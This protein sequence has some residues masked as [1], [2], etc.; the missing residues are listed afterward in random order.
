[1]RPIFR[2]Y[3][4]ALTV[5]CVHGTA[6]A[7]ATLT[8]VVTDASGAI[9]PGVTVET[10][11]P[12]LIERTRTTVTDGGGRYRIIDLP[13][14]VYE[15]TFTLPSFT[16]VKRGGVELEGTFI[17]T[18]NIQMTVGGITEV[19]TIE[20]TTPIVNISSAKQEDVVRKEDVSALPIARD[21]F[22]IA[23]L[24]PGMV[25]GTS[26][27]I[28][29]L[30]STKA[31]VTSFSDHGGV[32]AGRGTEGRLQ[33]DGLST[34]A[35]AL[36]GTGTGA[37]M[38]DISN[39]QEI[40]VVSSGGLGSSETGG[41]VINV[42]PRS[43]GNRWQGSYYFN[44]ANSDMQGNNITDELKAQNTALAAPVSVIKA[45]DMVL[46]GGGPIK[47]DHAWFWATARRN[48]LDQRNAI[49]Y[50][51]NAGDP[52]K[53]TYEQGDPSLD[54]TRFRQFTVRG[55]WQVSQKNKL[56]LAWDQSYKEVFYK[57]GGG[58]F[59]P[60]S[61]STYTSPEAGI[62]SDARPQIL[63]QFS[64]QRPHTNRLLFDAAV[65]FYAAHT[66]GQERPGN[67]TRDL[68]GVRDIAANVPG[69]GGQAVDLTYRSMTQIG[70]NEYFA[71]RWRA[72]AAY[73]RWSHNMRVGYDGVWF[74]ETFRNY[75]NNTSLNYQFQAG[76]PTM[77]SVR[78]VNGFT[79]NSPRQNTTQNTGVYFEDS[80]TRRRL[81]VQG[82]LRFDYA[83]SGND[84]IV[85]GPG[86]YFVLTPI[87]LPAATSVSGYKD[88]SPRVGLAYDV[89][90]NGRTA[91]KFNLGR[92][93]QEASN[94]GNYNLNN[95]A[96][97]LSNNAYAGTGFR[98]WT[99]VDKDFEI[100]CDITNPAAQGPTAAGALR[101]VDSCGQVTLAALGTP[102]ASTTTT[103]P[104]VLH[105]WGVRPN[106]WQYGIAVQQELLPRLSV[107]VGYRRRWFGNF[108]Y[109]NNFGTGAGCGIGI[110]DCVT[111]DQFDQYS[112]IAPVDSRLP[113][114][115]GYTIT[116]LYDPKASFGTANYITLEDEAHRRTVRWQ[117]VDIN[118]TARMHNGLIMRGGW[119]QAS[120]LTDICNT[121]VDN[122]EGLRT[123]RT[124]TPWAANA[125]F[126]AIY[127]TPKIFG[128]AALERISL[129]GVLNARPL[130]VKAANYNVPNSQ[131]QA[132][133]GR[134]PTGSTTT[135]GIA[136]GSTAKNILTD[137]LV[138]QTFVDTQWNADLRVSKIFK[139]GD[140]RLDAGVDVYNFL[141]FSSITS[142]DFAFTNTGT[143]APN[144]LRPLSIET[145]R[146]AKVYFQF[147]F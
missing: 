44:F 101:T 6:F 62:T 139:I 136:N 84:E 72:S 25:V 132:S 116:G 67:Q 23:S 33:V 110:K 88:L 45:Q 102:T 147:D 96:A 59:V 131:I 107:E 95:Q 56:T 86:K 120:T 40:S 36:F 2:A 50:N 64:W 68:I 114:G 91:L 21:W 60:T 47:R 103:D 81:T 48:M 106:D 30:T 69:L 41:P 43:G 57:G 144:Y 146:F 16:T 128:L 92:Y 32:S 4:V 113:D 112:I 134:P 7:Q 140:R 37:Y 78:A 13:A 29:G 61:L 10:A 133:L 99:D 39:A 123:C 24:V 34:G 87:V 145:A 18:I 26:Q 125:K 130:N 127:T 80:W 89:F 15:L 8:G 117:G 141:N 121:I 49:F 142:R 76:Q 118:V 65:S 137:E 19:V 122:P 109:T 73:V 105:G 51:K 75:T 108:T 93:L 111:P 3:A 11:S 126:S 31:I 12:A 1:M 124:I 17:G 138:N 119:V 58:L 129:S 100:D 46:G 115:G 71:P 70:D 54:D 22:S 97:Q 42:I 66:G 53:W 20:G 77:F 98:A 143:T 63:P 38:P 35:S 9:L 74:T 104:A 28:G 83:T 94:G 14:G 135:N 79:A 27:D 52:T 90:G 5:M 55:T 85:Y 82:A